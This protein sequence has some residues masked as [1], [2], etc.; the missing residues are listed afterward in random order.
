MK[1]RTAKATTKTATE[2][3]NS[4]TPKVKLGP[5]STNPPQ[6]FIL[7]EDIGTETRIVSLENPRY[8][9]TNRYLVC[10]ERGIY[11]FTK[12][13]APKTTPRSW[14]L[15]PSNDLGRGKDEIEPKGYITKAA[16][17]F[18]T[19]PVDPIFL[20]LPALAPFSKKT[21]TKPL[22][23]ASDDYIETIS[24]E[25]PHLAGYLEPGSGFRKNLERRMAAVCDTVDAGDD[26]MYRLSEAKL[27]QELLNKAKRMAKQGLPAS[28]EDKLIRKALEVPILSIK[29]DQNALNE[30]PGEDESAISD[31]AET[32]DT[33]TTN[34]TVDSTA[35]SFS[36][37]STAATS[38]SESS[39]L[40]IAQKK[41]SIMPGIQTPEGVAELLRVRTAFLFICSNYIPSHISDDLRKALA[42]SMSP[43]DFSPLDTYLTHLTKLR[44]EAL[45][46]RS[47]GDYSRK[48]AI[49]ED[50]ETLEIRAE[51]KRKKE[52]EDKR[53]NAGV[54]VG[55][56]KLQ[57]VNTTGMKKMS[58]FFKKK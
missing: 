10:P 18:V 13:A 19:T 7:P 1:T 9:S 40:P 54:S 41:E 48:R 43:I 3:E 8:D 47:M 6:L 29:R 39:N 14:L 17:L 58:D 42:S 51:K 28:M 50:D 33:Q 20:L 11:E 31:S 23:L 36:E 46:A 57:K 56:R 52:E 35:T 25:S 49:D 15:S 21:S 2:S 30:Q 22:F 32:P 12:V 34:S 55:L 38:F 4:S 5:D 26:T 45:A 37:A 27:L 24:H 16:D 53:K 44:Q